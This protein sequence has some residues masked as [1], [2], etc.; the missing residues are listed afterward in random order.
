MLVDSIQIKLRIFPAC[1]AVMLLLAL[2]SLIS[3]GSG[4]QKQAI[5]PDDENAGMETGEQESYSD[6]LLELELIGYTNA[7]R[8]FTELD[9][10]RVNEKIE[11][12]DEFFLFVGRPTCEWCRKIAPDLQEA[13][14][15]LEIEIFYLDS[16][17]SETNQDLSDFRAR[18]EVASVPAILHFMDGD[19]FASLDIDVTSDTCYE[20]LKQVLEEEKSGE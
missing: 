17:E 5:G 10:A 6:R 15:D 11:S 9:T 7:V 2:S 18:Y 12:E 1:C 8:R 3:C 19:S 13:A 20:D 4:E 14:R 16:T